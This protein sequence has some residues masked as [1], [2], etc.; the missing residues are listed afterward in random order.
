[1]RKERNDGEIED[2][3]IRGITQEIIK[4]AQEY[5]EENSSGLRDNNKRCTAISTT[6]ANCYHLK[7]E[8]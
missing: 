8:E 7:I 3:S 4:L 5:C 6:L 2:V 1:M